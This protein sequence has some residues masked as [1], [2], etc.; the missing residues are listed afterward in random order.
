[1]L[2]AVGDR[3]HEHRQVI[4][5]RDQ[6]IPVQPAR[7]PLT[8]FQGLGLVPFGQA[9][10]IEQTDQGLLDVRG[11]LAVRRLHCVGQGIGAV[12]TKGFFKGL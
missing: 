1:M 5:H 3:Q 8:H 7:H 12:F 10:V 4:Q 2:A 11:N 6:L 9:E